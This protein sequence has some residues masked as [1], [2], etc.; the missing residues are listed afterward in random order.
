MKEQHQHG[1]LKTFIKQNDKP[2]GLRKGRPRLLNRDDR[3]I[4]VKIKITKR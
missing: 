2:L 3:L 4:Q 1:L